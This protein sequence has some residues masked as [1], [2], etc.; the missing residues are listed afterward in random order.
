MSDGHGSA[1]GT[2]PGWAE[3]QP[4]P[5]QGAG[6]TPWTSPSDP[7]ADPGRPP[8]DAAPRDAAPR[9]AAPRDAAAP[10]APHAPP[11]RQAPGPGGP[12]PPPGGGPQGPGSYGPPGPGGPYGPPPYGGPGP[13]GFRP[14]PQAPRPGII[15]LRPL[16]L[17]DILDGTIKLI[18]SNPK[19][20]LGLSVI[21]ATAGTLP[22]AIGQAVYYRSLGG[23]LT[24]PA[25]PAGTAEVPTGG[26]VAQLGG[27]GL[28]FLIQFFVVT[29]LTGVLTRILGRAVFGGRITVGEAWRLTRG[30][31]PTLFGLALLAGLIGLAPLAVIA[32]LVW[33][34]VAAGAGTGVVVAVALLLG[35][36]Y[37]AYALF[38]TTRLALAAPAVVLEGLGV[39]AAMRRSWRL[40]GGGFWRV[41]GILV[42]TQLLTST[43]GAILSVPVTIVSMVVVFTGGGSVAATVITAV[44]F[45]VGGILSA[46][47]TYPVAAGVNG[48]LYT[49]R[50]MRAEAF[51]LVLQTA[52]ADQQRLG[53]VPADADHLWH[54]SHAARGGVPTGAP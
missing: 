38:V 24:D 22:L 52:A 15:P 30:R 6:G 33:A 45:A 4:P 23:L 50:R 29:V 48:L 44:L 12:Y 7:G 47:I 43:L 1:P 21:A 13:Y 46:M 41:L 10:P 19:A 36:A 5:Y 40:V 42:L 9:D 18:R 16:A 54:P 17:G 2:P 34:L 26:L 37:L 32:A 3:N 28:S 39:T 14:P 35:L 53:W 31:V 25:G 49:D 20:T 11:P 51:D 27:A 8:A